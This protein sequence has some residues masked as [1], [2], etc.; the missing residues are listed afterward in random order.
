L[1]TE[2]EI[3]SKFEKTAFWEI[4]DCQVWVRD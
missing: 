4:Y 3:I 2:E 1:K